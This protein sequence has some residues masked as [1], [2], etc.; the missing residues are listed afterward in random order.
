MRIVRVWICRPRKIVRVLAVPT[1]RELLA[2]Y[3]RR[4]LPCLYPSLQMPCKVKV[5][6][7]SWTG[8]PLVIKRVSARKGGRGEE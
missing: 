7:G 4:R 2:N 6:C 8:S 1:V 5:G 3:L